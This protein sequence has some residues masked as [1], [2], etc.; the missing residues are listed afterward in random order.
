MRALLAQ[1]RVELLLAS[2]RG[3]NVL[4]TLVV[5]VVLLIFFGGIRPISVTTGDPIAFLVPGL[6][7][8]AVMSASMVS[9]GIATGFERYYGV[10]KR[11]VGSPLPRGTLLLAKALAM[12]AIEIVQA[13]LLVGIATLAFGWR[14]TGSPLLAGLVLILGSL[15]FAAIGLLMAG[16]LRAEA[17][18]ALANGLYL[19]FLLMGGFVLPLDQLPAPLAAIADLLPAGAL[20]DATRVALTGADSGILRPIGVLAAWALIAG[21]AAIVTFRAD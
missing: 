7:A 21:G 20:A 16:T 10:L 4:V 17:T 6:L 2:R 13:A 15:A 18:L 8:L 19:L 14:P 9:L 3:E 1:T 12:L 11:L 5:P